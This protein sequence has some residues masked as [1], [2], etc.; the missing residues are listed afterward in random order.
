MPKSKWQE[1]TFNEAVCINPAVPLKK[2]EVFAFVD[3]QSIEPGNRSVTESSTREFNGGGS[4]FA[5]GDTLMA[6]ITPCLENGKIA[7]F[8][9]KGDYKLGN[10]STEFIVIRGK[11]NVTDTDYAYYLTRSELVWNYCIS[12]MTG[13]SGRQRVPTSALSHLKVLVPPLPE[14]RAI[15]HILGSLDDKIELNRAMNEMLETTARAIFKSWFVDFD[16]VRAKAEGRDT[17]LPSHIADLFPDSFEDSELGEIP[18][19]WKVKA[20]GDIAERVA[21]G[22][23]GSSIKVE[24]FVSE[25]I[26]VISGQHLWGLMLR[27]SVFNFITEEHADRL[28]NSIVQRGDVI[29]THAGSIG[30]ASFIPDNSTY[31]Q[32]IIS[33]RQFFMRPDRNW[34]TPS[35]IVFFFKSANGQ[36]KLLAN[37]SS[38]GVP[39]ISRP[40]TYLRS[41]KLAVPSISLMIEFEKATT[42]ILQKIR[43]TVDESNTLAAIRDALMTKLLNGEIRLK[44]IE[45]TLEDTNA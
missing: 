13:T 31:K 4:R 44:D 24:T 21:M 35:F 2:G 19:G 6:R 42:T 7:R 40:I 18:K 25:G 22:P 28:K 38:T 12:Q 5:V 17:G 1:L 9:P 36:H 16:P 45:E 8:Y 33:Q 3:M 41:I 23:F 10:G 11:E 15:A 39:S 26:P 30:Q 37:T 20:I 14:Q 43:H 29:F 27:D 32:Y 34:A